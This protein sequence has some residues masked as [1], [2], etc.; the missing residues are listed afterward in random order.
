MGSFECDWSSSVCV[1][2]W[3]VGGVVQASRSH[4]QAYCF[5]IVFD[6][7]FDFIIL[8]LSFFIALTYQVKIF[9]LAFRIQLKDKNMLAQD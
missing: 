8:I 5:R 6:L 9:N 7:S 4:D 2:T 1:C 3:V